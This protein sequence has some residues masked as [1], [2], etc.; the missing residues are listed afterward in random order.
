MTRGGCIVLHDGR[1][2]DN[3]VLW[4]GAADVFAG[5]FKMSFCGR[6]RLWKM[7]VDECASEA[8]PCGKK[9]ML[10]AWVQVWTTGLNA[11]RWSQVA[12]STFVRMSC[13]FLMVLGV[14]MGQRWG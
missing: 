13:T 10:I 12:R 1:W 2:S 7:L 5:E 8:G 3:G 14:D 9:N 11:Q 6:D 4:L